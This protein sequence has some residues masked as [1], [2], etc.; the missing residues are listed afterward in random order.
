[1]NKTILS[2]IIGLQPHSGTPTVA[3][4]VPEFW[5]SMWGLHLFKLVVS[6]GMFLV[7]IY[8]R[9][10]TR[11]IAIEIRKTVGIV[12]YSTCEPKYP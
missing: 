9:G 3:R 7:C 2:G 1:M 11:G 8:N 4:N 5:G 12:E 6:L 10:V